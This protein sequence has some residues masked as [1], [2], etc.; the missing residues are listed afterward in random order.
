MKRILAPIMGLGLVLA[1]ADCRRHPSPAPNAVSPIFDS[2][3]LK[4]IRPPFT[5][6]NLPSN[7][8]FLGAD[9]ADAY[10]YPVRSPD[11]LAL[12]ALL[13][14]KR[15]DDLDLFMTFYQESFEGDYRK[16]T[17]PDQAISALYIADPT[18]EPILDDWVAAAPT[19]FAPLVARGNYR[20][21]MGWSYRGSL[22]SKN[23]L[24]RETKRDV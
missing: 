23:A 21:R 24:N 14:F 3:A 12:L 13:R 8:P 7:P 22:L 1:F 9:G 2:A 20:Y 4:A 11:K 15:F 5:E 17:L 16:E 10:G 18:L 6:A 19:S